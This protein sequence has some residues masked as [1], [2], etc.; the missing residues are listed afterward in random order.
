MK[1]FDLNYN[2]F[3]KEIEGLSHLLMRATSGYGEY[4]GDDGW[5]H[6]SKSIDILHSQL[7]KMKENRNVSKKIIL[8]VLNDKENKYPYYVKLFYISHNS[9]LNDKNKLIYDGN[10]VN[11]TKNI[12][13]DIIVDYFNKNNFVY[14]DN[15]KDIIN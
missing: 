4:E 8:D 9:V 2:L 3:E 5:L 15:I 11:D 7:D 10:N 12:F 13:K 14:Q 1:N 6:D